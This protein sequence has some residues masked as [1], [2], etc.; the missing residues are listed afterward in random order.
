MP[1][2]YSNLKENHRAVR[3]KQPESVKLRI[4]RALSWLKVAEE[5]GQEDIRF[6]MLWIAFNAIYAQEY[7]A[8]ESIGD[9]DVFKNFLKKL[10]HL[11][12]EKLIHRI[13]WEAGDET[14]RLF[15]NNPYV[16][17][18]FWDFQRGRL[19]E[20][21][22]KQRFEWSCT[23]A[24][25]ALVRKNA[26]VFVGILFD[27]LYVLRNQLMHGGAT[28]EGVVN[29]EQLRSGVQI[30]EQLVPVII[31]LVMKNPAEDWG[32][33]CFPPIPE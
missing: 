7:K 21:D 5:S 29:R 18:W 13:V 19:P 32:E 28:F 1:I 23:N 12:S 11:D 24:E 26:V 17:H 9:R 3:G 25:K 15:I 14:L 16:S 20:S 22:W 6:L 8:E 33:P 30:L 4:H 27:R 10:V 31:Y 2:N